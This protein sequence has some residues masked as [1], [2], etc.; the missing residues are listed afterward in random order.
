MLEIY[1]KNICILPEVESHSD[2]ISVYLQL[3]SMQ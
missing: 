1:I 2:R 3:V